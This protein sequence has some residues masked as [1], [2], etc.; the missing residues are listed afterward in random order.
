MTI[1][2]TIKIKG[3]ILMKK[4][5]NYTG[6]C[7]SKWEM[8]ENII[9]PMVEKG[10]SVDIRVNDV[11]DREDWKFAVISHTLH[12]KLNYTKISHAELKTGNYNDEIRKMIKLAK[13]YIKE[14]YYDYV[15]IGI[16]FVQNDNET[17]MSTK[18]AQRE[19]LLLA[20]S[21]H[22]YSLTINDLT[23]FATSTDMIGKENPL[24]LSID[25]TNVK[26]EFNN[27]EIEELK[28]DI[29]EKVHNDLKE[30]FTT[31][32][33]YDLIKDFLDYKIIFKSDKK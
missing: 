15:T 28:A 14:Y 24:S 30:V 9:I 19:N 16:G 4:V 31:T 13:E 18:E 5:L 12:E 11:E 29:V 6:D 7:G 10:E 17:N 2:I 1:N 27:K 33:A 20:I 32:K 8:F 23:K 26:H 3:E 21:R 25:V 22:L